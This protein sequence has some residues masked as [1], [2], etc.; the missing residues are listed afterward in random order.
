MFPCSRQETDYLLQTTALPILGTGD[1]FKHIWVTSVFAYN[2]I[3]QAL[4]N[5]EWNTLLYEPVTFNKIHKP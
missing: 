3:K 2:N 1:G 4:F 5:N